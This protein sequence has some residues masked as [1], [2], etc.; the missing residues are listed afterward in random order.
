[1]PQTSHKHTDYSWNFD[2]KAQNSR[3]FSLK[4]DETSRTEFSRAFANTEKS[5]RG[6]QS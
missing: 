6:Q 3:H 2:Q 1:M 4:T 5:A